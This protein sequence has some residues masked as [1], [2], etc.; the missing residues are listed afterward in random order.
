MP[1]SDEYMEMLT[2]AEAAEARVAELE[3]AFRRFA[4]HDEECPAY[5]F[6]EMPC[7]CGYREV[8]KTLSPL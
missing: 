3:Q 4:I 5:S 6:L 7:G 2:R 1:T 8:L